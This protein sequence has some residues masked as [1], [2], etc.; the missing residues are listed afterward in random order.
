MT[1]ACG[2][3]AEGICWGVSGVGGRGDRAGRMVRLEEL[4]VAEQVPQWGSTYG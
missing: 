3:H 1:G 4:A 2:G